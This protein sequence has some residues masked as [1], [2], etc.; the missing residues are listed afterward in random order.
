VTQNMHLNNVDSLPNADGDGTAKGTGVS[1]PLLGSN[2][3]LLQ[4]VFRR[5]RVLG[6]AG[7]IIAGAV[8]GDMVTSQVASA[9]PLCCSPSPGCS[10][11]NGQ[12]CCSSGCTRNRNSCNKPYGYWVCCDEAGNDEIGCFDWYT[13]SHAKCICAVVVHPSCA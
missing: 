5:N 7:V 8:L 9:S 4:R 12:T 13:S 3:T 6:T 1:E 2:W 10:C 11:C